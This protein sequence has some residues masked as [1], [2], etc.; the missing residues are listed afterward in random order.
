MD[1]PVSIS[2]RPFGT[3]QADAVLVISSVLAA[4]LLVAAAVIA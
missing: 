2:R 3:S 1:D 4:L